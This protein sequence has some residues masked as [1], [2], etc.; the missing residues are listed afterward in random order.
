[1]PLRTLARFLANEELVGRLANSYVIRRL[2]ELTH[3]TYIK[4]THAGQKSLDKFTTTKEAQQQ[5]HNRGQHSSS[6]MATRVLRR[7]LD[8][9][10]KEIEKK[11]RR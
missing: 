10:R 6:M 11:N 9:L 8:N 1:M 2:A 3:Q 4:A 5:M 7:F